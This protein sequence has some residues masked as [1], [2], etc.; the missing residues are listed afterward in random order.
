MN[1]ILLTFAIGTLIVS[2]L[3]VAIRVSVKNARDWRHKT[4]HINRLD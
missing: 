2:A 1:D 3:L 4:R